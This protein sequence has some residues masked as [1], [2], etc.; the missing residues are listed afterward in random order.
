VLE[1]FKVE[2]TMTHPSEITDQL[3]WLLKDKYHWTE[4][5]ITEYLARPVELSAQMEEDIKRLQAGEP[6]AY[7]IGWVKFLGCHIDLRLKPLI[8]RP[9]T[10]FWTEKV[11][12]AV[13]NRG[14]EQLRVLDLCCGSGCIG[15]ALLKHLPQTQ[16]TF[17]DISAA[18]V[19]QTRLNLELNACAAERWSVTH[20]DLFAELQNQQFDCIV[21]NPPYV[22]LAGSFSP[23]VE[24]EPAEAIFAQNHGLELIHKIILDV[25]KH[26]L[27]GG[28]LYMEFAQGQAD[29][30]V[31]LWPAV[32][33]NNVQFLPDQFGVVRYLRYQKRSF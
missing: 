15:I 23:T 24:F 13:K 6:I 8:P 33:K 19:E 18:A 22:D 28:E 30:I 21:C 27:P 20:S 4:L 10:E 11:I 26:L 16:V 32:T 29:E 9:E 7:V 25:E 31:Q 12:A 17:T 5:Q 14:E 3:R 2:P 1:V